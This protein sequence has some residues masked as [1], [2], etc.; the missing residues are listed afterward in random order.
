MFICKCILY[1]VCIF[2]V[3]LI[4]SMSLV[5]WFTLLNMLLMAP[6]CILYGLNCCM[7]I[8]FKTHTPV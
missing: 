2:S 1:T 8:L 7:K 4:S 3:V 5:V 6:R